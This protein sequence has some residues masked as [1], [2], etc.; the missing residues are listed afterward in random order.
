[1]IKKLKWAAILTLAAL[2]IAIPV[3]W[4]Y[5]LYQSSP[6]IVISYMEPGQTPEWVNWSAR[7]A[8][9]H[10]HPRD[11]AVENLNAEAGALYAATFPDRETARSMLDHLIRNGVDVNAVDSATG[12]GL[13]AL[14]AAALREHEQAVELLL[15]AGADPSVEDAQGRTPLEFIDELREQGSDKEFGEIIA[16]LEQAE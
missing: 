8:F 15:A 9:F 2:M 4:A 5:T 12:S 7:K 14:H 13:T 6:L 3:S 11:K 16:L 1:M 10:F